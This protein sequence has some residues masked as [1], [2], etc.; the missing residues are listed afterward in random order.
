MRNVPLNIVMTY[1]VHWGRYQV[2]RDFVQNFYDA[3]G[4]DEWLRRFH[5]EYKDS[6]LSMWVE[7]ISFNY[8]WLMHIGAS[9]KTQN[10]QRYAG[11]FGEGFKIASLC[12]Y[13]D[14]EWKI[15]MMSDDWHIEVT[16]ID[17]YI[18]HTPVE[19]L[20]YN[21]SSRKK[22]NETKL[23]LENITTND[24]QLF[25]TVVNS[26]YSPDNPVMGE[27]L[28]Q[29]RE[30]AVFLRSKKHIDKNLPV[31][32]DYGRKGAVFCGYQMLGTNPFELVVCLH[33]YKKDD[34]ERRSLYNF[35]VIDVFE[36][37]CQY[38]D[39][40]CAMIMLEK[41]KKYW[42]SYP[43]KD[44]DI[45]SWSYVID[46]LI[47]RVTVSKKVRDS[48]VAR[49]DRLLCLK[50]I[51]T[52][53]EKNR[54]GEARSW[55]SQQEEH[56]VLVKDTFQLLGYPV[57]E[58]V[59]EQHGGFV[60]DDRVNEFQKQCFIVLENLCK[61]IFIGFFALNPMPE[62][63][64][65]TNLRAVYHGMAVVYKKKNPIPNIEGIVI[66]YDVGIIYLKKDIFSTEGYYNALSTYIHEMC[67]MFGGDASASFSSALTH[68]I[69]I[70]MENPEA[71]MKGKQEWEKIFRSSRP[72]AVM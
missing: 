16:C 69:E 65:I 28:W 72:A 68:T 32:R 29:G 35:E 38:V 8:E 5:Y 9:T 15:R 13:R 10:S 63:R 34:R 27:K 41:M 31:T 36:E 18:D 2:L 26:F 43:R 40:K 62:R 33:K 44:F 3:A 45:D 55:L 37:V 19:M 70:L 7:D 67:H 22:T 53:E 14:M 57:L 11:F 51:H 25:L 17:K 46:I 61:K 56:Y 64:I 42:N 39:S 48:F 6:A 47:R 20:A 60:I 12:A 71:V 58:D 50:K 30:G 66:R 21:I 52:I 49:N 59:C 23:I 4:Y 54:R 24:Y 1:P